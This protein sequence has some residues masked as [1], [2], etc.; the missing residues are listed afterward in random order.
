MD[1]PVAVQLLLNYQERGNSRRDVI[2]G[3]TVGE[4]FDAYDSS[5]LRA[6]ERMVRSLTALRRD[7]RKDDVHFKVC[8]SGRV[9]CQN[10]EEARVLG[11]VCEGVDRMF[12]PTAQR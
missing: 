2:L 5:H 7:W 3:I 9:L 6:I 10:T 1:A 8:F 11:A 4:G 12:I